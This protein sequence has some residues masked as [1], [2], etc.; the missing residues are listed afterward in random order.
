M[1]KYD[2]GNPISG[3]K[4]IYKPKNPE[5]IKRNFVGNKVLILS[6][7]GDSNM[8]WVINENNDRWICSFSEIELKFF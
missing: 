3:K 7:V 8:V 2:F 6:V 5:M 1:K 4:G